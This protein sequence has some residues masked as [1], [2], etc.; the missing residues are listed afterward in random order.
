MCNTS[1]VCIL[2]NYTYMCEEW[3]K[4]ID[5]WVTADSFQYDIVVFGTVAMAL[6]GKKHAARETTIHAI[7]RVTQDWKEY[8]HCIT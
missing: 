8:I 3:T 6:E 2:Y 5:I 1:T 7:V 4:I